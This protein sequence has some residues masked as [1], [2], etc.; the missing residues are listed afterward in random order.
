MLAMALPLPI[1][2]PILRPIA[3]R[4]VLASALLL[5]ACGGPSGGVDRDS[6]ESV[7]AGAQRAVAAADLEALWPLLSAEGQKSLQR[8]L[9][10][11]QSGLQDEVRGRFI[12]ERIEERRGPLDPLEVERARYGELADAWRF[13]LAAEPRPGA[14]PGARP[15]S[16]WTG[17]RW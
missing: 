16:R 14:P 9:E 10:D 15:R 6:Y 1:L 4:M 12:L 2:R 3:R 7:Y 13:Y 11:W 17:P 5:S 8:V